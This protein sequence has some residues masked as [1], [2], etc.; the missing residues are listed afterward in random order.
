M[1]TVVDNEFPDSETSDQI[2]LDNGTPSAM[3]NKFYDGRRDV[4]SLMEFI[5]TSEYTIIRN[6]NIFKG[7]LTRFNSFIYDI[8]EYTTTDKKSVMERFNILSYIFENN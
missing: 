6:S 4:L 5:S 1:R 8:V 3:L 2:F 7:L